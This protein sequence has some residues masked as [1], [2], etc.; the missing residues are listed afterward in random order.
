MLECIYYY[1]IYYDVGQVCS[2]RSNLH[3]CILP[4]LHASDL[5]KIA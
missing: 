5:Q 2:K 3:V 1:L 4:I